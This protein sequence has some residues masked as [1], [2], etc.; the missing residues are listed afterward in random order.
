MSQLDQVHTAEL[1]RQE[2]R[3]QC[4]NLNA[5]IVQELYAITDLCMLDRQAMSSHPE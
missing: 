1:D 5:Q 4:R 2:L 3:R